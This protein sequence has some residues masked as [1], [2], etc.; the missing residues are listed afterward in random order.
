[1]NME[2]TS[3]TRSMQVTA[4]A[5]V[6]ALPFD[7]ALFHLFS[8]L[9]LFFFLV[10]LRVQD[11]GRVKNGIMPA[12]WVH[13]SF[14]V[15]WAIML[16]TNLIN[17]QS[18]EAWRTMLQ[19]GPRYW[20]LFAIF[21]YLLNMQIIAKSELFVAAV[22]G[23]SLHFV[24]YIP[25][26][27]DFS[28]FDNRFKGIDRNPNTAGL[29]AAGLLMLSIYL[30]SYRGLV[31]R[32]R[33]PVAFFL[34]VMSLIVLLASGNRGSWVA[35]FLCS[36]ILFVAMFPKNPRLVAMISITTVLLVGFVLT[37]FSGPESRLE[38]LFEGYSAHRLA[39]WQ[40]AGQLFIER[41]FF[42]HGLDV[43]AELLTPN[44][45]YHEHN[46]FISVGVTMGIMGLLAYSAMLISIA[47]LALKF[48]N[49]FE[50]VMLL[51]M[52]IVGFFAYDFYRSQLFLGHFVILAALAVHN[53][54]SRP[55]T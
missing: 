54:S 2:P 31:S 1:M 45:I 3:L 11:I 24:P 53:K 47:S 29:K 35:V 20:L 6:A 41:P 10:S 46:I 25:A 37:Q 4:L 36:V 43:R 33:Y 8:F 38:L 34:G 50:L 55:A 19:F 12:K 21:A 30:A 7:N 42:G 18:E 23:L 44:A 22:L 17:G 28:I 27:L 40:N 48:G 39:I 13:M 52:M 14:L 16:I 5:L 49:H 15:I 9:L 51:M 32:I 26:M